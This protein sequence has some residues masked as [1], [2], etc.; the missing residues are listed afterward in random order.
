MPRQRRNPGALQL[1]WTGEFTPGQLQRNG[2]STDPLADT[3]QIV[4]TRAGDRDA[5]VEAIRQKWFFDAAQRR[6]DR[7]AQLRQ[8][9][10]RSGNVLNGMQ[11]YG[12]VDDRYR[13]TDL[14]Q[15]LLGTPE[16]EIRASEFA[17][18]LLKER[19]GF[20]LLNVVRDLQSRR[21][22]ITNDSLREAFRR[23]GWEVATNNADVGKLR[24]WLETAGVVDRRWTIDDV[25]IAQLTQTDVE[26][27]RE[28]ENLT[29]AQRK[30]LQTLRR[31]GETRGAAHIASPELLDFVR[32]EHGPIFNEGQV[33][34]IYRALA[35]GG[36]ITHEVADHGRGGKGGQITA[37]DK[38]L[39]VDFE[40]LTGFQSSDL[41]ADLRAV[42]TTPLEQI[43]ADLTSDNTHVKGIALELLAVNLAAD[44][45]LM[46]VRLRIRGVNTG[47]AEVDL[48]AE[49]AHLLF[50]RWL[51]QCKNTRSVRVDVLAKEVGM[52][53]LL[54]AGVI[55][56]ATTGSFTNT[57]ETYADRVS[58]T[59]PF[60]VVLVNGD[61][62]ERY[63]QGGALALREFFHQTASGSLRL[64]RDQVAVTLDKLAEDES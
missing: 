39:T 4:A 17:A 18:F 64:K 26:T 6:A 31:L 12:L 30:F 40:V 1:P 7:G 58:R 44:L 41:P 35:D 45:G 55:V 29:K 63:K 14:G 59:T 54:Q 49:G 21:E 53:T 11:N 42:L 50:S 25:R 46:P 13:L 15:R 19:K 47:G 27:I 51:F 8:Q 3:L 34:Q 9:Q 5:I 23:R 37:T 52:A 20:E 22:T 36:W 61:V 62:L 2:R 56:I 24:Q 48:V 38:L 28:W 10:T 43:H 16:A 57:V 33:R 60:Q 32:D